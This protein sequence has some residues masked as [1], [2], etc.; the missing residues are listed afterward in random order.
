MPSVLIDV[1]S[2]VVLQE[3]LKSIEGGE[4]PVDLDGL[5]N[6]I[7]NLVL[8]DRILLDAQGSQEWGLTTVSN[9]FPQVFE[10]VEPGA[11]YGL[12]IAAE[13]EALRFRD[14]YRRLHKRHY[15]ETD[16]PW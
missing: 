10:L 2:V 16:N 12:D 5:S 6:I 7:E 13:L 4:P 1:Y 14:S 3:G 8:C 9:R 11:A 15:G